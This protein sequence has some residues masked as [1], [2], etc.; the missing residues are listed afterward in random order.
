MHKNTGVLWCSG[1]LWWVFS[2]AKCIVSVALV[3]VWWWC[4]KGFLVVALWVVFLGVMSGGSVRLSVGILWFYG[5]GHRV[6]VF[7]DSGRLSDGLTGCAVSVWCLVWSGVVLWLSLGRSLG[8][9]LV[10]WCSG[11]V[12]VF[13]GLWVA[14]VVV[15]GKGRRT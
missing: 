9:S 10:W 2:C 14:L 12:W 1:G 8:L 5:T 4:L 3:L 15:S 11:L 13:S 7:R 6:R